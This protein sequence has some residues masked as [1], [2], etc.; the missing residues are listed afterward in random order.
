MS[1]LSPETKIKAAATATYAASVIGLEIL[2]AFSDGTGAI[3]VLPA[4]LQPFVLSLAPLAAAWL[5]GYAQRNK[6]GSLAPS[7]VSAARVTLL[8]E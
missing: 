4:W 2:N 8:K 7:T 6:P 1:I 3:T 5:A